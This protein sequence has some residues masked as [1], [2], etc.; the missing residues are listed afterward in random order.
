M[1]ALHMQDSEYVS[2]LPEDFYS[3]DFYASKLIE[4]L[5]ERNSID[6]EKPFFAYLP[7]SAPHWPLQA[8]K[9]SMDKYKGIYMDGPDALRL[10]RLR[11]LKKLGLVSSGTVPHPVI[12]TEGEPDEWS[13][14]TED[15]RAK[16]ARSMEAFAGMVDRMDENIGR[17]LEY[18]KKTNEYNNT[19]ILFMSDN[20]AEGASYEAFPIIGDEVVKHISQYYDNSLDNIGRKDSFVWYGVR[21]AQAATAPSRLY[22]MF[23][24][25][26]GCRVPLV[27]KPANTGAKD[28][29]GR[30]TDAFCTV[31]DIVPTILQL[32]G[33]PLPG[34]TYK[35]KPVA[36]VRGVSWVPF[37]SE[38]A[39]CK[40]G[41][42]KLKA[43]EIHDDQQVTGWEICGSGAIRK[44]RYKITYVPHPK[45]PEKWELFDI[46]KDPGEVFDISLDQPE[47]FKEL[48]DLWEVYK[49]EVG[50]VGLAGELK[51]KTF[52]E[53]ISAIDEF[54]D[55]GKWIRFMGRQSVAGQP[56][57]NT[58]L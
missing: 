48:L 54:E 13:R 44:G 22:K 2:V 16:S 29:G 9:S 58:K 37:L 56:V 45:G 17:V 7:F 47:V 35:G 26:G 51:S 23:S 15:E 11:N 14:L 50:V 57:P 41:D 18:L 4:F 20:G 33:L 8:P 19:Y 6:K 3:S 12:T 34:K 49:K 32:A 43:K 40:A 1:T 55:S 30:I 42:S 25:Q 39:E 53:K 46:V 10:Q 28:V 36:P 27:V 38:I 24:T 52:S 21:W 31:M 5:S